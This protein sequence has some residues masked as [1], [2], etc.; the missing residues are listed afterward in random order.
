MVDWNRPRSGR[1]KLTLLEDRFIH[2]T[3]DR[4][5]FFQQARLLDYSYSS[6]A[7]GLTSGLKRTMN[8]HRGDL[9][10]VPQL[11]CNSSFVSY[12][13]VSGTEVSTETVWNRLR[14]TWRMVKILT[15][16]T[17]ETFFMTGTAI[18]KN[19]IFHRFIDACKL[20]Y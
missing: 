2:I 14:C 6:R 1:Q 12:I 3:S 17:F 7:P 8:V 13:T 9:L 16:G 4:I 20:W 10:L 5:Y 15:F 19:E 11:Q 18:H